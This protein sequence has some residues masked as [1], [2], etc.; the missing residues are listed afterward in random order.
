M[1][2]ADFKKYGQLI[3]DNEEVRQ[4]AKEIGMNNLEGQIA[5]AKEL[6]LEFTVDDMK[7]MAEEA[8]ISTDELSDEQLEQV[9]GGGV[10]TTAALVTGFVSAAV[11]AVGVA[12]G[13]VGVA[14]QVATSASRDW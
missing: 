13:A 2:V 10:S 12:V 5:Y 14:T 6:G 1:S 9:A 11:G 8:G 4:K 7:D 3:V